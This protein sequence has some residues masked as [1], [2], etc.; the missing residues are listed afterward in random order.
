MK[1]QHKLS[2][3][4]QEVTLHLEGEL[5]RQA[6]VI[7]LTES[8]LLNAKAIQPIVQ[9]HIKEIV[10]RFYDA[11]GKEASLMQKIHEHSTI[12]RLRQTL[13]RHVLEM[14]AGRIDAAYIARRQQ[15]ART[16]LRIKLMAKW[17]IGS[18]AELERAIVEVCERYVD[19]RDMTVVRDAI[20]RLLSIEKQIV[21]EAF[22]EAADSV[23]AEMAEMKQKVYDQVNA[24]AS[25]LAA[26]AQESSA[27]IEEIRAQSEHIVA[28]A[29]TVADITETVE[30]SATQGIKQLDEQ[31]G[32]LQGI[33][34]DVKGIG[35]HIEYL[36]SSAER[37]DQIADMVR[38]VA[39]TTNL[40][41]LNAAI[42]AAQAGEHGRGFAVV[43]NEVKKL[44][45]QTRRMAVEVSDMM[46]SVRNEIQA[47]SDAVPMI[48]SGVDGAN[49]SME[50]ASQFFGSLVQDM[51]AISTKTGEIESELASSVHALDEVVKSIT[52]VAA[53]SEELNRLT[54]KL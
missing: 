33:Q 7:G 27:S 36:Q 26:V 19:A 47:V 25:E 52:Q 18:F 10:N 35:E 40:L 30:H 49:E 4:D 20:R 46:H 17:Y 14:L 13:Q 24:S 48:A 45:D 32:K 53:A 9:N 54:C 41:A 51:G 28:F 5:M 38:E 23:R 3:Q 44:A 16:H 15:V 39:D 37:V 29:R 12:D 2:I 1:K 8:D 43:A 6:D 22:D 50:Q 11:I 31:L 21:L 34:T 42:Q